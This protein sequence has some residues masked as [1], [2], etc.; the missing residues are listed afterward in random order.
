MTANAPHDRRLTAD[1]LDAFLR[2][3]EGSFGFPGRTD[4]VV[5]AFVARMPRTWGAF[6]GAELVSSVT[7]HDY[8]AFVAG[9]LVPVGGMGAVQ[10]APEHRRGG[11]AA[12]L[13]RRALDEGRADAHGW[14]LLYP[15]EASFYGR[16]G[17]VTVPTGVPLRVPPASL[18]GGTAA[19]TRLVRLG[20][21][22]DALRAAYAR[23]APT[24]TFVDSR[25]QGPW[26]VW[27]DLEATPG[28]QVLRYASEDAFLVVRLQHDDT[29]PRLDVLDLGWCDADGREA[30]F[31]A[32]AA[33]R[34][35]AEQVR[36]ELPWDDTVAADL[37]RRFGRSERQGLMARV[38]DAPTALA[39]L[40]A[41]ADDDSALDLAPVTLRLVD[42]F[43]PWNEG[44]WRLAPRPDGCDVAPA[45]GGAGA[46]LDV[47]AL[48]LLLAGAAAP[49]D[50][51]RLGLVEGDARVLATVAALSGGR[52]PYRSPLDRF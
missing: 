14:S 40:R 25:L 7:V 45:S 47:R 35:H 27:E 11:H 50:L 17:W 18:P 49:G 51:R 30:V 12:R 8:R 42:A 6:V 44:S 32:I 5:A 2:L 39:A 4:E 3:R 36:I 52:T 29:G 26:D 16:F 43:A 48:S 31:R 22:D 41:V 19:R 20:D 34:G 15:F 33:F 38:S 9:R 46:T 10:T 24:R 28:A 1:D 21:A 37:V 23:F 13:M